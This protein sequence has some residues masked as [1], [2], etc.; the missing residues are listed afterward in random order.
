DPTV[1]WPRVVE[2]AHQIGTF[3][4]EVGL[5]SFVKTSGGKGLHIVVPLQPKHDWDEVKGFSK[6]V[7]ELI[8]QLDSSNYTSNMAKASR[9][10]KIFVDYLRNGRTATAIAAYSTRAKPRATVS[11][12]L[13]WEELTPQIH[14]DTFTLRNLPERLHSLKKDPWANIGKVRQSLTKAV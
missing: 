9:G 10:G 2:S 12:P 3:L 7:A 6:A 5:K 14:S 4:E 8:E 13:T 1:T 11:V